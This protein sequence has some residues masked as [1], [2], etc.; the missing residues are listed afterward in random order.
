MWHR[1]TAKTR[2]V[3]FY[4]QQAAQQRGQSVVLPDHLLIALCEGGLELEPYFQ[5][6]GTSPGAVRQSLDL[7]VNSLKDVGHMSLGKASKECIDLAWFEAR[8]AKSRKIEPVHMLIAVVEQ[9]SSVLSQWLS[10]RGGDPIGDLRRAIGTDPVLFSAAADSSTL[11]GLRGVSSTAQQVIGTSHWF[12]MTL[13]DGTV[14]DACLLASLSVTPNAEARVQFPNGFSADDLFP[15]PVSVL[16]RLNT[17][18]D[19]SFTEAVAFALDLATERHDSRLTTLHLLYG[20][21]IAGSGP[22][23]ETLK[24]AEITAEHVLN[25]IQSRPADNPE[26]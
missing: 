26:P 7:P 25:E 21:C 20:L 1:F 22:V 8:R 18:V 3:I 23:Q 19:S 15:K 10:V 4:A 14:N 24:G 6:L 2:N 9:G 11:S 12:A 13:G 16:T 17:K 5:V